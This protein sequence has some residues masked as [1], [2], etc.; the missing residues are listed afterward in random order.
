MQKDEIIE[1]ELE[2]LQRELELE[3]VY[4]NNF[5][6]SSREDVVNNLDFF[7]DHLNSYFR[8]SVKLLK[9]QR[10]FYNEAGIPS[11]FG[12][13]DGYLIHIELRYREAIGTLVNDILAY[14]NRLAEIALG[15]ELGHERTEE[16]KSQLHCYIKEHFQVP[17][18]DSIDTSAPEPA[19][20]E[21]PVV[22]PWEQALLTVKDTDTIRRIG[23]NLAKRFE[24]YIQQMIQ[25]KFTDKDFLTLASLLFYRVLFLQRFRSDC[26]D[27]ANA[28]IE[29]DAIFKSPYSLF[30]NYLQTTDD[31]GKA[32]NEALHRFTGSLVDKL[33]GEVE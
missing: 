25:H 11:G 6:C 17:D 14:Q 9:E 7:R 8:R 26:Q 19:E 3:R 1:K 13:R 5:S 31:K 28:L 10:D 15:F 29:V 22:T 30:Y 24:T 12:V 32:I 23:H 33:K 2:F 18:V 20:P 27:E 16:E 4:V 21:L